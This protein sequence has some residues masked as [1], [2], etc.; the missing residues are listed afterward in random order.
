MIYALPVHTSRANGSMRCE[1]V[2]SPDYAEV[3]NIDKIAEKIQLCRCVR[4]PR[5][6]HRISL[7]ANSHISEYRRQSFVGGDINENQ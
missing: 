1:F 5:C 4:M 2:F 7:L 3:V 6:A